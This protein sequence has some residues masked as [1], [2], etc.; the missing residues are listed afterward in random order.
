MARKKMVH[1]PVD[2]ILSDIETNVKAGIGSVVSGSED[3]FRY[4]ASGS[5]VNFDALHDLLRGMREI[6]GLRFMQIDHANV[7]S[8][9]QLDDAQLAA[10]SRLLQWRERSDYLWV[11]MGVESANGHLVAANSSGKVAPFD[12][13]DWADMVRDAVERLNRTG[14]FPVLSII[15]GLPGETP[16]DVQKTL[17]LVGEM[18]R[19][20]AVVFPIF[21]EPVEPAAIA[22]GQSFT[23]EKMRPDHLELFKLCYEINFKWVPRLFWDN[24]RAGGVPLVKRA[25]MRLLG[26]SEIR[27]WRRKFSHYGELMQK[28]TCSEECC[29]TAGEAPEAAAGREQGSEHAQTT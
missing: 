28:R 12:P 21:H 20:R 19:G 27:T 17:E 24:Q 2:T 13:A 4:G 23:L 22:A 7:T 26:K 29:E 1:L 6:D 8:V 3:L 11:N 18:A 9:L 14:F 5:R 25:L 15:L 16:A 10:I